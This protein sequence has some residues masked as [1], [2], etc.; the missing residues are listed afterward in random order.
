MACGSGADAASQLALL[1][2][3]DT[4]AIDQLEVKFHEA[5]STKDL[6]MMMSLWADNAV[7]TVGHQTLTGKDQIRQFYTTTA[8]PFR[9]EN[10]WVSDTPAY[11]VRISVNGDTGTM[12]FECHYVDAVTHELK[13]LVTADTKVARIHGQWMFTNLVAGTAILS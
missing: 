2:T 12:Y 10:H 7:F 3:A 1:K 9:P 13:S 4:A 8:A 11:K 6:D 5:S